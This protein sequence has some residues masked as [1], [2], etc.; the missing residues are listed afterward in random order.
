M[1]PLNRRT[2]LAWT[3]AATLAAWATPSLPAALAA[4]PAGSPPP[5][6]SL[7]SAWLP[8]RE[9]LHFPAVSNFWGAVGCADNVL[10]I[11]NFTLAPY[12]DGGGDSCVL[13][14]DGV[15]V[16]ADAYR[17]SA[18]EITRK[19]T[20]VSGVVLR[21]ATR[22]AFERNELLL[23]VTV[24]NPTTAPI[25]VSVHADPRIAK[26][27][28]P[29]TWEWD[30]P[31]PGGDHT[32]TAHQVSGS[33]LL[34][35]DSASSGVTAFAFAPAPT[36]T[37][38]SAGANAQWPVAAGQSAT[39][40]IVM[41][42]GQTSTGAPLAD[43]TDGI[44]VVD[45]C[46]A[47]LGTFRG[48][49]D[50]VAHR[51]EQ[52]WQDAFTPGN[53]HYS[54]SLPVLKTHT[55][56]A[57]IAR[58][59][60]MSVLSLLACERT[61]LS[62][63]FSTVLG[64][65]STPGTFQGLDRVYVTGA[66]ENANTVSYFWD[67]S[68]ASVILS[69]LDPRM[70]KAIT[71]Y[72]LTKDIYAGYAI[73]WVSGN[74][75]GPWYSANDL[76]VFTTILNYVDYS[77]DVSFLDTTI[78]G[79]GKTVREHLRS[80][81]THWQSLVPQG[82]S[83]ADYGENWNLLEVLPKYTHQVASFN[84]ANVWMMQ[85]ASA[86]FARAGDTTTA[87]NLTDTA[88]TLL[89][90][91]LK[92]YDSANNGVWNC[93]HPDGTTVAVR[94]VLDFAIAGNLLAPSLTAD[95][96]TAMTGFV[97]DELLAGDWMRALSMS[98]SEAP[99]ARTDHGTSGA[100]VAWP[101]LTAQTFARFGDYPAFLSLLKR[102]SGVT[103]NGPFGQ[104]EQILQSAGVAVT[105]RT[106]LNPAGAVT[107]SAWVDPSSWP[108]SVWQGS[109]IAKDSWSSGEAGYVLRGGA[110]GQISFVLALDGHFT[111]VKTTATVPASGWHHVAGVYDG[112][113]VQIF[114][115]GAVQAAQPATG[116]I[117]PSTGTPVIVGNCPSDPTRRFSGSIDEAR[118]YTRALSATE[119]NAQYQATTPTLGADD[120][121]LVFRLSFDEG[122]G[123]KTTE[124]VTARAVTIDGATWGSGRTGFG[125]ALV[126]SDAAADYR[127]VIAPT[128]QYQVFVNCAGGNYAD[129][130]IRDLFGYGPDG[131]TAGLQ[132]AKKSRGINATL[133]GVVLKGR[134]QTITSGP[135]GLSLHP[136]PHPQK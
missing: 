12:L 9:V 98:D 29:A 86:L 3:G 15:P 36:L 23:R 31:R 110:G 120:S 80:I 104:S 115:D 43:V 87:K 92:L 89:S 70:V 59:Y 136:A 101:S 65:P 90:E 52:R 108:T 17:W 55:E 126:L 24:S 91:V 30:A 63:K 103:T 26:A 74:T 42:V 8:A 67:T 38:A 16:T 97:T 47:M 45:A 13:S 5:L 84:A 58:L 95:Q 39:I 50:A 71:A 19:A 121:S 21:T 134:S 88:D 25:T 32:F 78:T 60:Y 85:E 81:A 76:T 116:T 119:I 72:W 7:T 109:I 114:I 102:F 96:K 10:A 125:T 4:T 28:L 46:N 68:Y 62:A 79:S 131:A 129:V 105:D 83:L 27:A 123:T 18:Y 69:L 1:S 135:D 127:A 57:D 112:Q 100:Y 56:D 61:N 66:P 54:G 44:A 107:V 34:I 75:V 106:A 118:I 73:D 122:H 20:T 37:T 22:L 64:R 35:S 11:R 33:N 132:D 128:S 99:V 48:A 53:G 51:W 124:S 49:F 133:S 113:Q 111:E 14:V 82:Q 2:F 130:I 40:D 94:H 117:A 41:E 93:R 6:D 77:G